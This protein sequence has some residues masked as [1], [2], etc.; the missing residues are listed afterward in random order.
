M[1]FEKKWKWGTKPSQN[2]PSQQFDFILFLE[3]VPP[4]VHLSAVQALAH[5]L[6]QSPDF[7]HHVLDSKK[8]NYDFIKP[9]TV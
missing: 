1:Y 9:Y 5:D 7:N 4:D 8:F 3:S 6:Q 2:P